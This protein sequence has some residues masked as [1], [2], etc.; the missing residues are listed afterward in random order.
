MSSEK[1]SYNVV[2]RRVIYCSIDVGASS[3]DEAAQKA[4]DTDASFFDVEYEEMIVEAVSPSIEGT[5]G[6]PAD[7]MW[8]EDPS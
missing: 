6:D 3:P 8:Y 5:C 7:R 2:M 1:F 4:L